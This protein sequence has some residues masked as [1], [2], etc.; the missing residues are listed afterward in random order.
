MKT[1]IQKATIK[2]KNSYKN[3]EILFLNLIKVSPN[4][5]VT[6]SVFSSIKLLYF[7]QMSHIYYNRDATQ[8]RRT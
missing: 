7:E 1:K 6:V 4:M 3:I 2:R 8:N 5:S